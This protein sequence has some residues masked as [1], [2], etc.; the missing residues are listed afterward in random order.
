MCA[1]EWC[2]AS[3][4]QQNVSVFEVFARRYLVK[5]ETEALCLLLKSAG[6]ISINFSG[7]I[8]IWPNAKKSNWVNNL[9]N[10]IRTYLGNEA[11]KQKLE[12]IFLLSV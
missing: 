11:L 2:A 8:L 5:F 9:W 4:T 7:N 10:F 1:A 12:N 6:S 3:V